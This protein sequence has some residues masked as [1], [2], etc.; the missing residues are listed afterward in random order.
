VQAFAG[1]VLEAQAPGIREVTHGLAF[2]SGH[3]RP[4]SDFHV[5][6]WVYADTRGT[7][8]RLR[9]AQ[10]T[11]TVN[12]KGPTGTVTLNDLVAV[13]RL[14]A[15]R[16][17]NALTDGDAVIGT[18]TPSPG[19]DTVAPNPPTSITIGT[20]AYPDGID[21]FA[22]ATVG[23]TAPTSNT[24][25]TALTD[26]QGY[27]ARWR[28]PDATEAWTT[29]TDTEA[30]ANQLQ[31]SGLATG[32]LFEVQVAAFDRDGNQSE[33]STAALTTT[34]S[35]VTAPPAPSTPTVSPYLGTLRIFWDGLSA[36][37]AVMPRDLER[38]EIHLSQVNN[39]TPDETTLI[40]H[41]S[42][43]QG[44]RVVTDLPYGVTHYVRL[45]GVDRTGNVGVP[46]GVGSAIPSQVVSA[47]V[48][49]GAIGS[50]QLAE[51]AVT[52]AKINDLAVNDAKIG[53]LS[54]GKLTSGVMTASV[55]NSG[56]VRSGISGQRYELDAAALRFYDSA[57]TQTVGITGAAGTNFITGEIRSAL[58]G[59]RFVIN[60]G[61]TNPDELPSG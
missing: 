52:T 37:G 24:D 17:L 2:G 44:E 49:A 9:V 40:D 1:R 19:S 38:V 60:P 56:I 43:I 11:L 54:V 30:S 29:T 28:H 26:L 35:D 5:G 41:F 50:E 3:P 57:G 8:E 12:A 27:R 4:L 31:I 21:H 45:V 61:G 15:E 46:S 42:T 53:D 36:E 16:R 10:W 22:V 7:L 58:T 23:W 39:F 47:D 33:W 59:A 55:T 6:D 14:R 18:S 25:G 34:E 20:E 51:L 48:F 13:W 32:V